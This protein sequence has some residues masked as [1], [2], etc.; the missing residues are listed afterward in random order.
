MGKKAKRRAPAREE[1]QTTPEEDQGSSLQPPE[2]DGPGQGS[3]LPEPPTPGGPQDAPKRPKRQSALPG[4]ATADSNR[5]SRNSDL[6]SDSSE[7]AEETPSETRERK[8]LKGA[9]Q[10]QKEAKKAAKKGRKPPKAKEE[11]PGDGAPG[12]L[13]KRLDELKKAARDLGVDDALLATNVA[14]LQA[15]KKKSSKKDKAKMSAEVAEKLKADM[16]AQAKRLEELIQRKKEEDRLAAIEKDKRETLEQ[17]W[18]EEQLQET[19]EQIRAILDHHALSGQ[20]EKAVID[21]KNYL[22]CGKLPSPAMCDQMNTYLHLWALDLDTTTIEGA[23]ARTSDAIQLMDAL[24]ELIDTSHPTDPKLANW[25]WI[26]GLFRQYQAASLDVATYRLLR[27]VEHNLNRLNIATA[28]FHFKDDHVTMSL[29]LRVM[30]PVPLPNPRRP[31]KPRPD[32]AFEPLQMAALLPPTVDC[33]GAAIRAMYQKYDHLSDLSA[34]YALP[35]AP[36]DYAMDLLAIIRKEWRVQLQ[37]KYDNRDDPAKTV[38]RQENVEW[39]VGEEEP[40]EIP[41]VPFKQ[42]KPTASDHALWVEDQL[43]EAAR[44]NMRVDAPDHVINLRRLVILGGVFHLNLLAQPPQPQDFVTMDLTLTTLSLPKQLETLPFRVVYTPYVPA[45]APSSSSTSVRKL[46]EEL[47][48]EQ[49][50]QE[51]ELDKLIAISLKWPPHV[52]FLELP[53]VCRW[54]DATN[55]WSTAEIHDVK[56]NEDKCTLSFRTGVFGVYGLATCR[57]A[58]L[59]FQAYDIKPEMDESVTVQLTAAILMLEFNVKNGLIAITQLQNSPNMTLQDSVGLYMKLHRLKRLMKEAGIDIFPSF[60]AFCYVDGCSEKQW[61]MEQHLYFNVAQISGCFNFAWSRWNLQAGR[62]KIVLQM[63]PY[64]PDKGS[65]QKNH[66]TLLVT[67]LRAAFIDCTEVSQAFNEQEVE[68]L[69][70]CADLYHLM[71]TTSGI[72]V[73][74]KVRSAC[75]LNVHA[76]AQLLLS[77]RVLSFS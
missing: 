34:T 30:L 63:R 40:G 41:V 46:P 45:E 23:S 56:H 36:P 20:Q 59:P 49:K 11:K 77:I 55:Q 4:Q 16:E 61:P 31:P 74:N 60:D 21:W 58:N 12:E 37:Y 42:L 19:Q 67:P 15:P 8:S 44:Q 53:V 43:Y 47:E 27:N 2:G 26:G 57:Y 3:T 28:D 66:Q 65:K 70:F 52:I 48:E 22:E 1:T 72:F 73:R 39:Q 10:K 33:D 24:D 71:A 69:K 64:A 50:R 76:L 75:P 9:K 17:G 29:W 18:R 35:P 62:R 32:I 14:L 38:A 6:S 51:E 5:P 54:D 7:N 25:K 68:S 13:K